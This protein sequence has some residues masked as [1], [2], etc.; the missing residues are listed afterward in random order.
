MRDMADMTVNA[1]NAMDYMNNVCDRMEEGVARKGCISGAREAHLRSLHDVEAL[2]R[3]RKQV[4]HERE[5]SHHR[6]L[7]VAGGYDN[8][9]HCFSDSRLGGMVC[10]SIPAP[11]GLPDPPPLQR[12]CVFR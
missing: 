9:M 12:R 2:A 4:A 8:V 5:Y 3:L 7:R 10:F 1:T 11:L 6:E